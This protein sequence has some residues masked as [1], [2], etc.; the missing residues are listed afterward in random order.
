M[1]VVGVNVESLGLVQEYDRVNRL[2]G[3][4]QLACDFFQNF[5]RFTH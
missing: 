3:D 2:F 5:L 1:Y 4:S